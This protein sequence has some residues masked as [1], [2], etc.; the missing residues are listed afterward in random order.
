MEFADGQSVATIS[1]TIRDDNIPELDE[2][3]NIQLIDIVEPG[4]RLEGRGARLGRQLC[5]DEKPVCYHSI[6]SLFFDTVQTTRIT[7]TSMFCAIFYYLMP[8]HLHLSLSNLASYLDLCIVF[9]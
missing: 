7:D 9:Q 5:I 8:Q 2:V 3:S 4:T 6:M 1:I